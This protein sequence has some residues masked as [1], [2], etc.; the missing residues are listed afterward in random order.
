[1]RGP[2]SETALLAARPGRPVAPARKTPR[3]KA[4]SAGWRTPSGRPASVCAAFTRSSSSSGSSASC[5][6]PNRRR[7]G[8]LPDRLAR[9]CWWC[10]RRARRGSASTWIPGTSPIPA[11]SWRRP[12]TWSASPGMRP[13]VVPSP[14][15]F[16]SSKRKWTAT[17][18]LAW[19]GATASAAALPRACR[20]PRAAGGAARLLSVGCR[21]EAPLGSGLAAVAGRSP[22]SVA[23]ARHRLT[24]RPLAPARASL[25]PRHPRRASPGRCAPSRWRR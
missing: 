23:F 6:R 16:S 17:P 13:R 24:A 11:R 1:M 7:R 18:W 8:F 15:S 9:A 14:A 12:A 20:H 19:G 25:V 22:A 4:R 21:D 3:S 10:R 2:C 5:F